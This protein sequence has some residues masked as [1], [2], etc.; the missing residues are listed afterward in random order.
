MLGHRILIADDEPDIRNVLRRLLLSEGFCVCEAGDGYEALAAANTC[1]VSAIVMDILMPG[2]N[3]NEAIRTLR[4]NP[5]FATTP[6]LIITGHTALQPQQWADPR[7]GIRLLTKPLNLDQMLATVHQ[8]V[9][10]PEVVHAA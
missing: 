10:A 8:L 6:I 2:M 9:Q 4:A 5:R 3:G 1:E 7:S